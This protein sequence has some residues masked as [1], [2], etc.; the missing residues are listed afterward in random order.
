MKSL[1]TTLLTLLCFP[2]IA[3]AQD[4]VPDRAAGVDWENPQMI[5]RNKEAPHV[6]TIPFATKSAALESQRRSES[7]YYYSLNGPWKFN[8]AE[9]PDERPKTFFED[10]FDVSGWDDIE[11]PCNWEVEGYGYPIYVNQP[12]EFSSRPNPP[13]IPDDRN[14]VGSFKRN[15]TVPSV[16]DGRQT[17]LHFGAVKSAAYVWVN[18]EKVGYTQ[19]SKTPAEF[20]IT[21]F[22]KKGENSLAVEVYRWSD[23]SYL[24][25]QDFWRISGIERDVYLYSVPKVHVWDYEVQTDLDAEY[26]DAELSVRATLRNYNSK[27]KSDNFMLEMQ[28]RDASGSMVATDVQPVAIDG[29]ESLQVNFNALVNNPAKWTAET[30]ALHTLTLQL[31]DKDGNAVEVLSSKVG[32]REVEITDGQ[33][34]INGQY[35]LIKGVN[36]HEHDEFKGHVISEESMLHDITIMKQNNLNAV[37][38]CHYPDD[39]RWYELCDQYG[40]YIVDEANIE[41]HGMGYGEASLAHPESWK[42]AHVDRVQRM[43]ERDKNHACIVTWSLG[44]EGG[45]GDN[46][47]AAAAWIHE[48]EPTR[49]VQYERAGLEEYS[50]IYCPMYP[51]V[52]YLEKYAQDNPDRPLIMCEYAHAMGNSTGNLKEYWDAIKK[53]PALQG[54]FIWDWVDQGLAEFDEDSVKYWTYGGDYGKDLPSDNNFLN[55]GLV[56]PDRTPHP[57]MWEVKKQYQNIAFDTVNTSIGQIT[58]TNWFDF[59]NLDQFHVQWEIVGDGEELAS[60]TV[61]N[62]DVAPH[63]TSDFTLEFPDYERL[64]GVEYFLNFSAITPKASAL[65]PPNHVIATAQFLL[66]GSV[67]STTTLDLTSFGK[68]SYDEISKTISGDDFS[69]RFDPNTGILR[70]FLSNGKELIKSGPTPNFWRAPTD[71]DFGNRMPDKCEPWKAAT[72]NRVLSDFTVNRRSDHEYEVVGKYQLRE[73]AGSWTTTYSILASAEIRIENQLVLDNVEELPYLPRFGMRMRLPKELDQIS[74]FGRGPWENY[75]DRKTSAHVGLYSGAVAD[76]YFSYV[77]PQENGNRCDV[78]W[79]AITDSEGEGLLVM[80]DPVVDVSALPYS[81]EDLNRESRADGHVND[82]KPRNFTSLHVD[83]RQTGVGGDNSWGATAYPQY[84]LHPKN[85]SYSYRICP[86]KHGDDPTKLSRRKFE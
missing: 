63:E 38:T 78:R 30:P 35:V 65:L 81:M 73:V 45:N 22:L 86:I 77:S 10:A 68:L 67:E 49:P 26:R 42:K 52:S 71:N 36:R 74:W 79:A 25:C 80:G 59:T 62:P 32:F 15:F 5:G 50:D 21:S 58:L 53:Y 40:L 66:P 57:A 39:P 2:L 28:L 51:G 6:N 27:L 69:V 19:G 24:E 14:P 37:R 43:V 17:F 34:L 1:R 82:L 48:R 18:G 12:Y 84:K 75:W 46:F 7:S 47:R 13:F 72:Y 60:G 76:Q 4:L 70:S 8:F 16:W 11:V 9:T 56:L 54:G 41:S 44:N 85:Y 23:G 29:L 33:F 3:F 55:N 83:L 61:R 31:T 64:P 20:D